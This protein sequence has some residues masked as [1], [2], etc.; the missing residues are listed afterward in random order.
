MKKFE[1]YLNDH[2]HILRRMMQVGTVLFIIAVPLLNKIGYHGVNGTFYSL[3]IGELNIVDPALALQ[4]I[5][6]TKSIYLPL[7]LA[8]VLPILLAMFLG[9]VFCSW[10]CPYNF[11]AEFTEK[12]RKLIKP[13]EKQKNTNPSPQYYWIIFGIILV[14]LMI[15]GIPVITLISMPGLI[16]SQIADGILYNVVGIEILLIALLL[17]LEVFVAPRFWCK[18][19]CP[20]GATLSLVKTKYA[21]K[22]KYSAKSCAECKEI[23]ENPCNQVCPLQLNPKSVKIYPYCNN[24]FECITTCNDVGCRALKITFQPLKTNKP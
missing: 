15:T 5:L 9:K 14:L 2:L 19:A 1:K 7:I 18:Y 22:I 17:I 10:M 23:K 6:L 4:T 8:I 3:S 20:V 24:C 12:F 13:V 21:L 11:L 16:T